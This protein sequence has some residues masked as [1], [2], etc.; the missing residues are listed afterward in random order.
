[1][2]ISSNVKATDG[3][4]VWPTSSG[5][6]ADKILGAVTM[7]LGHDVRVYLTREEATSLAAKLADALEDMDERDLLRAMVQ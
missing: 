2:I 4:A 5:G 1:V 3:V 6:D 7:T